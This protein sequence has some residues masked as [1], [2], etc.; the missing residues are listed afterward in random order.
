MTGKLIVISGPSGCGKGTVIKKLSEMTPFVLSVSDTTRA[1][2]DGET[3]G[4]NYN[5]LSNEEFLKKAK[6]GELLEY[7]SYAGRAGLV[8]YYGTPKA[9]VLKSLQDGKN[10][11][12]E[13]EVQ[14]AMQVKEKMPEA[15]LIFILP[16][17]REVL[18]ARLTG[19]GTEKPEDIK[20]RLETAESEMKQAPNFDYRVINDDL[21]ECAR[22]IMDIIEDKK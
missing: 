1:I 22:Q 21:S 3:A 6:Q 4:V 17:S 15:V 11:I 20:K 5:Y 16:P 13:I 2:R 8:T 12:L 18:E 7:A 10:V 19:R 14:G 9:Q